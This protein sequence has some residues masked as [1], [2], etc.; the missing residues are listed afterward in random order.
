MIQVFREIDSPEADWVEAELKEM[1]LGYERIITTSTEISQIVG[2]KL[3]L[4][5]LRDGDRVA[6]GR[7]D[8]MQ[9]IKDLRVLAA[10]WR[11]FEGD[12]CYV[13]ENGETC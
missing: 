1:V 2:G 5:V 8:L 12:W 10:E 4:P 13:D 11:L 7:E 6:S 3:P 9:F